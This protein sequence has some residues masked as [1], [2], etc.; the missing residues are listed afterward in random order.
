MDNIYA[1]IPVTTFKN[2]KT[3]L[4]PFLSA[5]ERENL[6]KAML[7]DV[8]DTLKKHVDKIFIISR[9]EDVL[10]YAESLNVNTI[11]ENDNSNLNK[12]LT[13]AMKICKGKTRKIIIVPS[14][15]PLIGKTNVQMLID[16]SK[17]L[18][19]IIVPSKGGGTNMIIM[20]PMAIHTRFE[21]FSYQEHIKAAERKKLNP[22]VHDSFFMALDVNTTEDLGEIMLHGNNTHTRKYLKELKVSVESYRGSERL[23]V[24][25]AD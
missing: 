11:Q 19:F 13:Q 24:T 20:K 14:D 6:L 10:R 22:Q 5:E 9:D 12:A 2:A 17:S 18:D 23:K 3:R 7:R 16:A 4:S 25:R 15:I 1:I 21:G 8:T